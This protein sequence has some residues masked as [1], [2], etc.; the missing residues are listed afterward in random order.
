MCIKTELMQ[1]KV[2]MIGLSLI[3][4]TKFQNP[5]LKKKGV[6]NKKS[7]MRHKQTVVKKAVK[8]N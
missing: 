2:E 7:N 8:K 4:H 5:A 6:K 3:D 1:D